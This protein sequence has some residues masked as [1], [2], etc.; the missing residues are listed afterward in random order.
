MHYKTK[1][2]NSYGAEYRYFKDSSTANLDL[3]CYEKAVALPSK[4]IITIRRVRRFL[5]MT[6]FSTKFSR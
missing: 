5:A 1:G 6:E 2:V 3:F 4:K